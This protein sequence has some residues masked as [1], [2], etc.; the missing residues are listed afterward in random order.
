MGGVK[1][2]SVGIVFTKYNLDAFVTFTKELKDKNI[3]NSYYANHG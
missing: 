1:K 3:D 2:V